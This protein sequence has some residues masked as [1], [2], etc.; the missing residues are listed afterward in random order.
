ME[1]NGSQDVFWHRQC[2]SDFTNEGHIQRLQKLASDGGEADETV[3]EGTG[4]RRSSLER[5][6]WSK[7]IF[8]QT[9]MRNV[10]LSQVQTFETSQKILSK[11]VNDREMICRLA[12]ISDLI[13]AE[14][15]YHLKCYTR[16]LKKSTQKISEDNED[17][18]VRCFKEV[19]ALL[20]KRLS[21]G[22]I[23]TL[24]AVWTYYSNRLEQNYHVQ[25][26]VY[27]S[28]R[29]KERIQECLGGSVAF[30]PPLN[31]SEPHLVV[32]SNLGDT[33]LQHLLKEPNQ[34]LN[35]HQKSSD[36]ELIN[37]AIED[38]DLDAELLSWLYRVSVKV[39]QD[40]KAVLGHDCIS[41]INEASAEKIVPESLF[42]LISLLCTGHQEE[43]KESDAD[44]KPRILSICQDIL[45]LAS[46]GRK[47]TPKHVGLGLTVQQ[48]TRS[49]EL[50]QLLY[51][52][53]HSISY[54]T[55][56]RMDNTLAN[57]VLERYKENGN[58]FVPRNF[59]ESSATLDM[60]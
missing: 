31:L 36:D 27:R 48:A 17:A 21:Q 26:N 47:L 30:V 57:D 41:N 19:M 13:A 3:P 6:D 44:L 52:A 25:P 59:A 29:F 51:N 24:K 40:V 42:I 14:G 2:Y 15:K 60:L 18:I 16:Y 35:L 49:K 54:E 34:Q 33:A 7:C 46:R 38:V 37:D 55:V 32:S 5:M 10:V 22:R 56:L 4:S 45:F 23:Y 58:V 1:K 8:C 12:G 43:E 20:E 50:V 11:T 28:N 39:H 9:D 53:G